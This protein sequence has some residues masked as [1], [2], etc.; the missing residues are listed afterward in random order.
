M[1]DLQFNET[2]SFD[3]N[4]EAFLTHMEAKDAELG[5]IL[6]T[7]VERLEGAYDDRTRRDARTAFNEGVLTSLDEALA[8]DDEV[9]G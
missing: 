7:H 6:R 8:D 1:P 9:D 3:D 4:I 2:D 5:A